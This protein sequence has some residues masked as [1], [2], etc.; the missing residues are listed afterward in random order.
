M[1]EGLGAPFFLPSSSSFLPF[2][3]GFII[4]FPAQGLNPGLPHCRWILYR[5]SHQ[6][7][8]WILEWVGY[9]FPRGSSHI[10]ELNQGLLHCRQILY[11]LS[12]LGSY[13]FSIWKLRDI[14]IRSYCLG[15]GLA[16]KFTQIFPNVLGKA[17]RNF[18]ANSIFQKG[19]K[20]QDLRE[21]SVLERPQDPG[22]FQVPIFL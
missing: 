1:P 14:S 3:G 16:K 5:L 21:G 15:I 18:L 10:Q 4:I 12:Y 8:P 9:P 13:N 20:V 19:F 6:R 2:G 22:Q 7:S 11:Q 17:Q